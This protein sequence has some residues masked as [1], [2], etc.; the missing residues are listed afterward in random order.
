MAVGTMTDSSR[1]THP[2][3]GIFPLAVM[4]LATFLVVFTVMTARLRAGADPALNASRGAALVAERSGAGALRTRASGG[5]SVA[6]ATTSS[7]VGAPVGGV[8]AAVTRASGAAGA[9][10]ASDE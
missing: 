9:Q 7:A 3:L 6:A 10:G 5:A 4:T 2:L 8:S 1:G